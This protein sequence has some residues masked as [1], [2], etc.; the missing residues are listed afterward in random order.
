MAT[1]VIVG[2]GIIILV[3]LPLM[4]LTGHGRQDVRAAGLHHRDCAG[5]LAGAGR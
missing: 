3:F 4:T 1:P 2:V 5:I